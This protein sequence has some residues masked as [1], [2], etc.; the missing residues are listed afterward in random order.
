MG[1]TSAGQGG[2]IEIEAAIERYAVELLIRDNGIGFPADSEGRLFDLFFT[3][4]EKGT[5]LGLST[6]KKIL[7]AHGA[8]IS[9]SRRLAASGAGPSG[10]AGTEVRLTFP[11]PSQI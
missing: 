3:T 11:R 10:G 1:L 2:R 6:V 7:D 9:I 5:G 8:F 4:K